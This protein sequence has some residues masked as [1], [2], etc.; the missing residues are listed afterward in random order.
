MI[1]GGGLED[2]CVSQCFVARHP[3]KN[4]SNHIPYVGCLVT[5]SLWCPLPSLW[6]KFPDFTEL[7]NLFYF[8]GFKGFSNIII[9]VAIS[10]VSSMG[11]V[12]MAANSLS[13]IPREEAITLHENFYQIAH[14]RGSIAQRA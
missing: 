8:L 3:L 13:L 1:I 2:L 5:V 11:K 9:A 12:P 10:K 6:H 14:T 4:F 7:N